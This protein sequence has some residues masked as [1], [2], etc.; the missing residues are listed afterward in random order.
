[1][2]Y[3][4]I[5]IPAGRIVTSQQSK[6]IIRKLEAKGYVES[7]LKDMLHLF[8][9]TEGNGALLLQDQLDITCGI[10][11][12]TRAQKLCMEE[13]GECLVMNWTHGTN[14]LGYHLGE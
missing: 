10:V 1:M 3:A 2:S 13:W 14:N 5:W 9:Q 8:V 6:Y 11:F 7:V 12:Q 4:H